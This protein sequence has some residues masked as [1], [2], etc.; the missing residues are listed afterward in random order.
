MA[1]T[2]KWIKDH[3]PTQRRLI[4]LYTALLYNAQIKGF[5]TGNIYTGNSKYLCVPGFNC[6]SCPGAVGACPLGAL[7]NALAASGNR[8]PTYVIGILMLFGLTLGR[9]ICGWFCPLGLMQELLFKIPTPKIKK[10]RATRVLSYLKYV[11]LAVFVVII[12]L[13][14][15]LQSYPVPAFCKYICPAGTFE[16]AVGL[17]SN[18]VNE[19]AF[20]MLGVLFTRK[21]V[22]LMVIVLACV[23]CYRAFCRFI[24]PLGAI[25]GF[26]A[27]F[28]VIGVKVEPTKCTDCGRCVSVCQM[29]IHC[30]GDHECIHCGQCI[31]A[32]PTK[33]ISFKAGKITLHGPEIATAAPEK[34]R[35]IRRNRAIAWVIALIVLAGALWYFNKP[36]SSTEQPPV[37]TEVPAA[38]TVPEYTPAPSLPIGKEVGMQAPDFTVPVYGSETPFTLSEHRGKTVIVNFWATWCTPCC[39][40]LPYFDQVYRDFGDDVEVVAIHSDLVTDDVAKYLAGFDYQMPFALDETGAVIKSF[41]G[42]TMLPMTVIVDENGVITYNSVG[43]VTYEKLVSLLEEAG[44]RTVPAATEA[45]SLPIGKEVGM[46][47][48]DFT[49]PVYGSE[50]PFTLSQHRGKTVIVNFWATWCTPCCHELPYF[51]QVYRDFGDDVEVVA[52][53]SDLVTDDVAKYLAGFDYQ[54]PFALDETGAVI[55]SFGGSTM[56]PMTVIVD[57]NGVITYN[58]VGSVTYEK[59]VSLLEK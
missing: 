10:G 44:V 27:R 42:S 14:Y 20:G 31:D 22:I 16:G 45:P 41:G 28:A 1:N 25:Y 38:T 15:S 39:H 7:Q 21:F 33:A 26:F 4:Q 32:C 5:I 3:L 47:A 23:F 8:W 34:K 19:P 9:T 54:M 51:D 11:I 17:L 57:E 30:V 6:Y 29:D 52:I 13:W 37:A 49:V 12:P 50:T 36:E 58:S 55:K 35:S 43:S 46:Q 56:L 24:C 2:M 48:P 53:H 18:P 59:L 40:E